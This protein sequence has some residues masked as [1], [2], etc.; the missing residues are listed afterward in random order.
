MQSEVVSKSKSLRGITDLTL[1]AAIR[2]EL[3]DA[4][5]TRTYASRLRF[6]LKALTAVRVSSREYAAIQAFTDTVERIQAI[7]SFRLAILEPEQK[8]LLAV[9]FDSAWEPYIRLIWR[10][11]GPLLDVIF[12]NCVG[13]VTACGHSFEE[14][15]AWVRKAQLQT[16]FFYADSALTVAD[17]QYLRQIER[18]GR[19]DSYTST[20]ELAAARLV[21]ADREA[22][23]VRNA[24][25]NERE[26]VRQGLGALT[27]LYRLVDMY[28]PDTDDGDLLLRAAHVLLKE[29]RVLGTKAMFPEGSVERASFRPQLAWFERE[30]K[31]RPA[32]H[33]RTPGPN[34]N[35][36]QGGILTGYKATHGALLLCSFESATHAR[37]FLADLLQRGEITTGNS[38]R[39]DAPAVNVAFTY[40]GL[41]KIGV[42]QEALGRFPQEFRE[43]MEARAG[44]LGDLRANHPRN[45]A[46]PERNSLASA[47]SGARVQMSMVDMVVQL[48]IQA[49]PAPG[50][51][52]IVGNFAHPLRTKVME[53]E[54]RPGLRILSVQAMRRQIDPTSNV[55][56]D[57]FGFIDGISQPDPEGD[58]TPPG[59]WSNRIPVGEVFLGHPN[60]GGDPWTENPLLVDGTYLV[61]RKL[62]QDIAALDETLERGSQA[63]GLSADDLK[64]KMM[65]RT[66]AG[67]AL[68]AP[69]RPL[70]NDFDYEQ[71]KDGSLC[72]FQA[73]I[74]RANPRTIDKPIVPRIVR[75]GMSYGPPYDKKQPTPDERGLVFMAYN[76]SIAGQFEVIQRWISGGNS[77]GVFSDQ[78]DPLLGVPQQG[79]RRMFRFQHGGSVM[80]IELEGPGG[81]PFVQVEWGAYL[82]VP[83]IPALKQLSEATPAPAPPLWSAEK[84]ELFIQG[85]LDM[86]QP[87]K[88]DDE[89][90]DRWKRVLEDIS[91]R[92]S[93]TAASVWA[94]IRKFHGGV[95]KTPYGVLV[96]SN[97][98]VRQ[99]F[100]DRAE[101]YSVKGYAERMNG[102]FGL[103]FLGLDTGPSYTA[104]SKAIN[105][106]LMQVTEES[107]FDLAR[108]QTHALLTGIFDT[109]KQRARANHDRTW[110]VTLDMKDVSDGVL[111]RL[112]KAWFG[113]PDDAGR[114][115][116]GGWQWNWAPPAPPRCPAHFHSPSRYMFQPNP[117]PKATDYGEKHGQFLREAF[118]HFVADHRAKGT[119]SLPP[120]ARTIFDAFPNA[121]DDG[122]LGSTFIGVLMGFLPTVDGNLRGCLYEWINDRRFWDL[123]ETFRSDLETDIFARAVNV[124][125]DPL[126]HTMQLRPVPEVT[127]RI[128]AKPHRLGDVDVVPGDKIVNAIVSATQEL[129]AADTTDVEPIFGG[130]RRNA[131]HHTHAC[132]AYQM[133]MGVLLG[134]V[135]GLMEAGPVWP[136]PAPLT[137][138]WGGQL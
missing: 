131:T 137:L 16:E 25:G 82:F 108:Q 79:D 46:L 77:T 104:Q 24:I 101:D 99:V 55:A 93:N 98:L 107:A 124:L 109:A 91:S 120:L 76:A 65:G 56:R 48:S 37:A 59:T 14:Y 30:P 112:S 20:S 34:A 90:A 29:L 35:D 32:T 39:A 4:L 7:H 81:R 87:G 1:V 6:L 80:R 114:I 17:L 61:I 15:A 54:K 118:K 47:G 105:Q 96:A 50:D 110:S 133:G 18:L 41:R 13:Y 38:H 92:M 136:T 135:T 36:I 97:N 5:D 95:L 84:G 2:P 10:D 33:G 42:S 132:P 119:A 68:G 19:D 52:E 71:D 121:T 113:V 89:V 123:Q 40:E 103:I 128:A 28:P 57:H 88:N 21:A 31:K 8:L 64:A 115:E 60:A 83:S 117:G 102:S 125:K 49:P 63:V 85:L 53:L 3:I 51:H 126:R 129:L 9:T 116:P 23:A 58:A 26:A 100:E 12:C 86:H 22:I 43:G 70:A 122:L 44:V 11:L 106:A 27:G 111:A 75:R 73:H 127:W 134:I 74:R 130:N 62:R 45:W 138:T 66:V 94:A 78:S 69:G 67:E 72:P